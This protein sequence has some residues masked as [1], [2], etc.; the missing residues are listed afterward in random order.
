MKNALFRNKTF[1]TLNK[2][3]HLMK[4]SNVNGKYDERR[5]YVFFFEKKCLK[6]RA[7]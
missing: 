5:L 1:S 2:S 3:L 4:K 7:T 6:Q